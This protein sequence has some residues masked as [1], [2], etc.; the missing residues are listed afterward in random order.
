MENKIAQL[1]R[2]AIWRVT[3]C[4]VIVSY[5][6]RFTK[7]SFDNIHPIDR[8]YRNVCVMSFSDVV[9]MLGSLLDKDN[10][11]ISFWNWKEFISKRK[12]ELEALKRLFESHGLQEIRDQIIAHQDS[13]H[14]ENTFPDARIKGYTHPIYVERA[15]HILLEL[16]KLFYQHTTESGTPYSSDYFGNAEAREQIETV[17]SVA[18]PILTN[19]LVA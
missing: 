16:I 18:K 13:T 12:D 4:E 2:V 17:L 15:Q 19:D 5:P 1:L 3:Y 10:R 11:V 7:G 9:L 6:N 14:A 8:F